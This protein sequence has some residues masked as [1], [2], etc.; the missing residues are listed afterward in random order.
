MLRQLLGIVEGE[1]GADADDVFCRKLK[2]I[3][4]TLFYPKMRKA[5]EPTT[6][7]ERMEQTSL[8]LQYFEL[9]NLAVFH[10]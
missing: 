2:V 1:V 4:G 7:K 6:L 3:A 5:P 8:L 10:Q 9:R